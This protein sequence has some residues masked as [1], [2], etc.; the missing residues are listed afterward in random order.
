LG[1]VDPNNTA[2]I[3][4]RV[5]T[6]SGLDV[7]CHAIEFYTAL[8]FNQRPKPESSIHR[9]AYQGSNPI[10]DVWSIYALQT[11]AKYLRRAAGSN[12]DE[13]ARAQMLI[14]SA[15]AGMGFGNAGVHLRHGVSY[16]ISSQ[17]RSTY[18]SPGGYENP[19]DPHR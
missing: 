12:E 13:E 3:P 8:P 17:V 11:T 16:L 9:P 18:T 19:M 2:S 15:A 6:Y 5:A 7:L 1:I 14:A 10:S 4:L